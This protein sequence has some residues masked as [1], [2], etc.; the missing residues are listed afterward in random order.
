MNMIAVLV[1]EYLNLD[2]SNL[3]EEP[4]KINFRISEGRFGLCRGLLELRGEVLGSR[5]DAH[6]PT[7]A[8]AAGLQQQRKPEIVRNCPGR[9]GHGKAL[10]GP[11]YDRNSNCGGGSPRRDLVAHPRDAIAVRADKN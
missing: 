9:F 1:T 2:V 4:L 10:F 7:A 5:N 11:G 3:R 8:T 6:P